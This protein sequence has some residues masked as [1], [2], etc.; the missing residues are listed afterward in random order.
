MIFAK[1]QS[2]QIMNTDFTTILSRYQSI[3]NLT[4]KM[5]TDHI[6]NHHMFTHPNS[7]ICHHFFHH[8]MNA[9]HVDMFSLSIIYIR[10]CLQIGPK[11]EIHNM[12]IIKIAIISHNMLNLCIALTKYMRALEISTHALYF[13][14]TSQLTKYRIQ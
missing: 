12:N 9:V 7:A 13:I 2:T 5:N 4:T 14:F 3:Q 11:I 8:L 10:A 6:L 1:T